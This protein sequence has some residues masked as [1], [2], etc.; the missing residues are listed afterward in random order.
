MQPLRFCASRSTLSYRINTSEYCNML[1]T[2]CILAPIEPSDGCR[3]SIMSRHTLSDGITLD[4]R[5][6]PVHYDLH[7]PVLAPPPS[8]LGDY[9]KRGLAWDEFERRFIE[10]LHLSHV[11][12]VL[13]ELALRALDEEV[14]L[15]CIE[16]T[17][18][19][20][21]R[22]IVAQECALLVHTLTVCIY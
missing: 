21:H 13:R 9:Y 16:E 17:P 5:I 19:Y 22:R 4:T 6:T 7:F 18:E 11:M 1:R 14:T 20:C 2:K 15:L 8:L 10:Y 3:I 12:C